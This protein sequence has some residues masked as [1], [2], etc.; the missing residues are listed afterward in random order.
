[1]E[2]SPNPQAFLLIFQF[3]RYASMLASHLFPDPRFRM[4]PPPQP[5]QN[6][7]FLL[8]G[9]SLVPFAFILEFFEIK[10]LVRVSSLLYN[11]NDPRTR[12]L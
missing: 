3:F 5:H 6:Q 2:G 12:P 8:L 9:G 11:S 7:P 4:R 10:G 1:R